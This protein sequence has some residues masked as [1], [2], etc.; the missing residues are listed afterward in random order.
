MQPPVAVKPVH[1]IMSVIPIFDIENN[2]VNTFRHC[3]SLPQVYVD[4]RAPRR[5]PEIEK[6]NAAEDWINCSR[7]KPRI[8]KN[9]DEYRAV[10]IDKKDQRFEVKG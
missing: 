6:Q 1:S 2:R 4:D 9:P 8:D 3:S 7:S 10:G 5:H